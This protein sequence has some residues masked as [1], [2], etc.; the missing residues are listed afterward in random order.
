MRN[1]KP[2]IDSRGIKWSP[3]KNENIND[4]H[5]WNWFPEEPIPYEVFTLIDDECFII[6]SF[7]GFSGEL[8]NEFYSEHPAG[9][10][11]DSINIEVVVLDVIES[12][13]VS[14]DDVDVDDDE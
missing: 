5:V 8:V 6:D 9:S 4:A 13:A 3:I 12:F 1:P 10:D 11:L 7:N 2:V 14:L